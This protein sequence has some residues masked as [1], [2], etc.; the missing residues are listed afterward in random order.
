MKWR[1]FANYQS[2]IAG[3]YKLREH[4]WVVVAVLF[5]VFLSAL[6]MHMEQMG[7]WG[8]LILCFVI[9][10]VGG[11]GFIWLRNQFPLRWGRFPSP[12]RRIAIVVVI[13]LA[14]VVAFVANRHKPD[15]FANDALACFAVLFIVLFIGFSRLLDAVRT[16]FSRR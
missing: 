1:C 3:M 4:P 12:K 13:A 11:L 5:V 9:G 15:E 16:R 7:G 10:S 14:L 8:F 2:K 6:T